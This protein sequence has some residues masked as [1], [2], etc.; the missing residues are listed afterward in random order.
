ME[1]ESS[2]NVESLCWA[3]FVVAAMSNRV[4]LS[5]GGNPTGGCCDSNAGG[6]GSCCAAGTST[7]EA[8]DGA[9][10]L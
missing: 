6:G 2:A 9:P 8:H 3:G 10:A 1:S 5:S 4:G 7:D